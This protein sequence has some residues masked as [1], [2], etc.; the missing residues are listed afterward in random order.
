VR[1]KPAAKRGGLLGISPLHDALRKGLSQCFARVAVTRRLGIL[2][3][4]P[5]C[6]LL[7][8]VQ[9]SHLLASIYYHTVNCH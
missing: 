1:R 2:R 9:L 4:H 5:I 8:S 3:V 7:P 6:R